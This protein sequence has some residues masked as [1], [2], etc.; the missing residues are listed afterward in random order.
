MMKFVK[1]ET[2]TGFIEISRLLISL[3]LGITCN[4][5]NP[6]LD[7]APELC[8]VSLTHRHIHIFLYIYKHI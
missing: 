6:G 4:S 3:I 8:M 7:G 5:I 1:W 2:G